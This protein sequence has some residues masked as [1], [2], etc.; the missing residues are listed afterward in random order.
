MP[1]ATAMRAGG[2]GRA[3]LPIFIGSILIILYIV[4]AYGTAELPPFVTLGLIMAIVIYVLT[5][6]DIRV[7]IAAMIFAIAL[8]PDVRVGNYDLRLEDFIIPVI[9]M[10]W[11]TRLIEHREKFEPSN[12]KGPII[13]MLFCHAISG[14]MGV[15][16]GTTSAERAFFI[17]AKYV[18]YYLIF[19]I[20]LNNI[21]TLREIRA[22][23]IV[24]MTASAC[25]GAHGILQ[26]IGG[27]V[28]FQATMYR[29]PY[30]EGANI[31]GGFFVFHLGIAVGILAF[32]NVGI[33]RFWM[34]GFCALLFF[35]FIYTFSR[36]S[37]VAILGALIL[38][39]I[40]KKRKILIW[41]FA[42]LFVVPF[43]VPTEVTQR[44]ATIVEIVGDKPPS[45]WEAR[46]AGWKST[47]HSV[48]AYPL[49]GRGLGS[50]SLSIDNEAVRILGDTGIIGLLLFIWFMVRVFQTAIRTT[51]SEIED[52]LVKGFVYG[53]LAGTIGLLIHS[54]GATTF[55]C[56]RTMEPFMVATAMVTVIHNRC[57]Q[58]EEERE[59]EKEIRRTVGRKTY[60]IGL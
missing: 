8:S 15:G 27:E 39:A 47:L 24:L 5:F 48:Y 14:L 55:T 17:Y 44:A 37:Y 26:F 35:P 38:F 1:D 50:T 7:G 49:F 29:G 40:W 31:L 34:I 43:L 10:A 28:P 45:S 11:I 46:V 59:E 51:K 9:F 58:W 57:T 53:Y 4:V 23:I 18:Q 52:K 54:L 32:S 41:L 30:G 25:L 22:F 6:M 56:I 60:R 21:K 19:A 33:H 3:V 42:L 20:V 2:L 12:L 16:M 36:T 13:A